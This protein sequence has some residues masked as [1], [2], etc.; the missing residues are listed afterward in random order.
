MINDVEFV[1]YHIVSTFSLI[2]VVTIQQNS[3]K[4]FKFLA[5]DTKIVIATLFPC[6]FIFSKLSCVYHYHLTATLQ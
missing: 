5:Q 3:Y 2:N 1:I 6:L 4:V